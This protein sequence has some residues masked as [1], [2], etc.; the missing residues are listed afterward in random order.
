MLGEIMGCYAKNK[1]L[2][3]KNVRIKFLQCGLLEMETEPATETCGKI[4]CRN[5]KNK[6]S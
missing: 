2:E 5:A 3:G 4:V 6:R 1:D